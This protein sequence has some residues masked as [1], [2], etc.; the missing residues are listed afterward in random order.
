MVTEELEEERMYAVR[1]RPGVEGPLLPTVI[2][3]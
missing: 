3:F 2:F 1:R